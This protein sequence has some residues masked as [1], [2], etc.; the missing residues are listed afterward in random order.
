M[1]G[2]NKSGEGEAPVTVATGA[3]T[4]DFMS[5]YLPYILLGVACFI[6]LI[7]LVSII[8]YCACRKK[9]N[10]ASFPTVKIEQDGEKGDVQNTEL[11]L[12][13][14][15]G[16]PETKI[17]GFDNLAAEYDEDV[18]M[19]EKAIEEIDVAITSHENKKPLTTQ[20]NKTD[21]SDLDSRAEG[22]R[23]SIALMVEETGG[24]RES[25]YDILPSRRNSAAVHIIPEMT[26]VNIE[27]ESETSKNGPKI[28]SAVSLAAAACIVQDLLNKEMRDTRKDENGTKH[29]AAEDS[30]HS[31]NKKDDSTSSAST[32]DDDDDANL[33]ELREDK[34]TPLIEALVV[35]TVV[36]TSQLQAKRQDSKGSSNDGSGSSDNGS[37][38]D[39]ESD[40]DNEHEGSYSLINENDTVVTE[41]AIDA[42]EESNVQDGMGTVLEK[43]CDQIEEKAKSSADDELTT[44][45][46]SEQDNGLNSEEQ[47][48]EMEVQSAQELETS[49]KVMINNQRSTSYSV[50]SLESLKTESDS[51]SSSS[52]EDG[53]GIQ[54]DFKLTTKIKK[55]AEKA[56]G[57]EETKTG[58]S[59]TNAT[60]LNIESSL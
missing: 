34:V 12:K 23:E 22:R 39:G 40:S 1:D 59:G 48:Q 7:V 57:E 27:N 43:T 54:Y 6:L 46:V 41:A 42:Q 4:E 29:A 36:E 28:D 13:A 38:S 51:S 24:Q 30:L 11:I 5:K 21:E 2:D 60:C 33:T 18:E 49:T 37:D 9:K 3:Q 55:E 14:S 44:D 56:E 10:A 15:S 58:S 47:K 26:L 31:E 8:A 50:S 45:S 16:S 17:K 53:D 20:Q 19:Y 35:G 32:S 25:L 52:S